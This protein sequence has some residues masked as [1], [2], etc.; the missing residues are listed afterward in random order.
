MKKIVIFLLI[1]LLALTLLVGCNKGDG[2]ENNP[3]PG[4][5]YS[6]EITLKT[7]TG[8]HLSGVTVELSDSDG[9]FLDYGVTDTQ[10]K[11]K[12]KELNLNNVIAKLYDV[13]QGYK[14]EE[15]YEITDT[16]CEI[17]LKT[18]LLSDTGLE[19]TVY[20][21]GDIMRDFTLTDKNGVS[22]T[23]SDL[24]SEKNAVVLNFWY[25]TCKFC[26]QEFPGMDNVYSSFNNKLE[27]LAINSVDSFFVSATDSLSFPLISD[28]IGIENAFSSAYGAWA[29][30]ATVVIDRYGVVSFLHIGALNEEELTALFDYYTADDYTH[31]EFSGYDSFKNR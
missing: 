25:N 11:F 18:Q 5:G 12:S 3:E 13:P 21:L 23:L 24:L 10:G 26:L 15:K 27:I 8:K 14:V 4:K 28:S 31:S 2:G 29:N 16:S 7:D 22:Y 17:L 30:P 1:S 19:D 20:R 6:Y 9:K